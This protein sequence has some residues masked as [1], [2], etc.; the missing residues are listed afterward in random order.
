LLLSPL[1]STGPK[2][3]NLIDAEKVHFIGCDFFEVQPKL[4]A[5]PDVFLLRTIIHDWSDK[6]SIKLLSNLRTVAGPNTKLVLIDSIVNYAC[7]A[8]S[9]AS[10]LGKDAEPKVPAPLLPNLG[11]ANLLAYEVDIVLV[12]SL[13]SG[14]RTIDGYK[15]IIEASGWKLV[16]FR[17][18]PASKIWWPALICV[19]A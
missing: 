2:T 4:P 1:R 11:G 7:E 16:E 14:E 17:K 6:Y 10:I 19:P 5:T 12:S 13:N 8:P 18:N 3:C 15:N 9:E